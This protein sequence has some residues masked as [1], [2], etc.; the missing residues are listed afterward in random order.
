MIIR[1]SQKLNTKIKAGNLDAVPLAKIACYGV[2]RRTHEATRSN[3]PR[4]MWPK[5]DPAGLT[6][7]DR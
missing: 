4:K 5:Q 1:L 3:S 6:A 2:R 7:S